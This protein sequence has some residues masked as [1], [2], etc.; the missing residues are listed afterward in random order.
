MSGNAPF[1]FCGVIY[2]R[3]Q[4]IRI[5]IAKFLDAYDECQRERVSHYY[6]VI[7]YSRMPLVVE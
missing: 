6:N 3:R 5:A 4:G 2:Q 1:V 7:D